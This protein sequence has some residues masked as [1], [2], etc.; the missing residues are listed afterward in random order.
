M[1]NDTLVPR[2]LICLNAGNLVLEVL[3]I[4][5]YCVY[6]LLGR[7]MCENYLEASFLLRFVAMEFNVSGFKFLH[8]IAICDGT[9]SLYFIVVCVNTF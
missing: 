1:F 7:H 6:F 5:F 4:P 3:N 2:F 9:F 8:Y